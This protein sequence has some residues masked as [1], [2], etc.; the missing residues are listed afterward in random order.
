MHTTHHV[1]KLKYFHERWK[2]TK[3]TK[4]KTHEILALS[5]IFCYFSKQR[6]QNYAISILDMWFNSLVRKRVI[7]INDLA[8][9][10]CIVASG[11]VRSWIPYILGYLQLCINHKA[12]WHSLECTPGV[13]HFHLCAQ[14]QCEIIPWLYHTSYDIQKYWQILNTLR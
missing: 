5:G 3:F 7:M 4:L 11:T 2:F 10:I 6:V 8:V 9:V 13:Q 1:S 12:I 14:I